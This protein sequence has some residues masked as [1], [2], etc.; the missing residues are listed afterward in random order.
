MSQIITAL[1]SAYVREG[2]PDQNFRD[3]YLEANWYYSAFLHNISLL[4][5]DLRGLPAGAYI[6][7]AKLQLYCNRL[8]SV[9][10]DSLIDLYGTDGTWSEN[11]VTY[12]N[13]PGGF[14]ATP[15]SATILSPGL[16][17][18]GANKW[19][20]LTAN[21]NG[22][23]WLNA[24]GGGII[25]LIVAPWTVNYNFE[26]RFYSSRSITYPPKLVLTIEEVP[27]GIP[28]TLTISAPASVEPNEA[29]YI[30][31][32]LYETNTGI[33]IPNQIIALSYNGISLGSTLTGIDG[34]Y[35]I[36]AVISTPG[37]YT[38]K[39]AYAGTT[40][41]AASEST[42]K[43]STGEETSALIP[44]LIAAGAAWWLTRK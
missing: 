16:I 36:Q 32:I 6:T 19:V 34:D 11:T 38:L 44:L 1:E 27:V 25:T 10:N 31:G 28:T 37:T 23:D 20:E 42:S 43:V 3:S 29:F 21:Q 18:E 15:G 41:L 30:T 40:T 39:A 14:G 13:A 22:L 17:F 35:L 8:V 26:T 24:R 33:P 2:S 7:G 12:N 4:K 9:Y 5:F